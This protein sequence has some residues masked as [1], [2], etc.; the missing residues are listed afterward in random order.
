MSNTQTPKCVQEETNA[1]WTSNT[2]QRGR[3]KVHI[4]GADKQS[5]L[6]ECYVTWTGQWLLILWKSTDFIFRI[7]QSKFSSNAWSLRTAHLW[8]IMQWVVVIPCQHFRT[9]CRPI[10]KGQCNNPEERSSHL[11]DSRSLKSCMKLPQMSVT[12]YHST[13][14]QKTYIF[15]FHISSIKSHSSQY[16]TST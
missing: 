4:L 2:L 8:A 3:F 6:L 7:T 16:C 15:I 10:F 9:T 12:I 14:S 1:G 13:S 11:L 5:S